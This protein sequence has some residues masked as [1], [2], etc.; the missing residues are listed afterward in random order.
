MVAFTEGYEVKGLAYPGREATYDSNSQ[1][2]SGRHNGR[3]IFYVFGRYP[4]AAD[5]DTYPVL[6]LVLCHGDFL[7]ANHDYVHKNR[8]VK[9]FGTYGDIMIR[10]RKMYVAPT[11][12]GLVNGVA[13]TLTLLL[14]TDWP[15]PDDLVAVGDLTRR[16]AERLIVGYDFDLRT[17]ILEPHSVPN[18]GAGTEHRF[19]AWRLAGLP[20]DSVEMRAYPPLPE[21]SDED[22]E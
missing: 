8:S 18:P 5:G 1:V 9:G 12:F 7:N 2:P 21:T 16:E 15:V 20:L 13:H 19:R 14:P 4:S 22:V 17:N 3:T 10:D 6:D 11:P